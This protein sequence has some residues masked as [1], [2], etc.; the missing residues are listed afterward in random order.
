MVLKIWGKK[1][2]INVRQF[3]P[4]VKILGLTRYAECLGPLKN[5][6][7]NGVALKSF[8]TD[9]KAATKFIMETILSEEPI[10]N[11]IAPPNLSCTEDKVL[12]LIAQGYSEYSIGT[13]MNINRYKVRKIKTNIKNKFG[14]NK[15]TELIAN[16]FRYG[17][18]KPFEDI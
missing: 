15:D 16:A 12:R 1:F 13:R 6:G 4:N 17:Y 9:E 8:L 14:A 11:F 18:L 2:V 5:S 10:E 3:L 7:C